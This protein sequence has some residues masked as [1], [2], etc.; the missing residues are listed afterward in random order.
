MTLHD[1][2]FLTGEEVVQF[3][4][5]QVGFFGGTHQVRDWGLLGSAVASAEFAAYYQPEADIFWVAAHYA[6]HIAQNQ[7][8][9][10]GNK[11]TGLV[12][13]F[14]FLQLNGQRFA[15][16]VESHPVLLRLM[17]DIAVRTAGKEDLAAFFRKHS[18]PLK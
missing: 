10:D 6:F 17:L 2:V 5:G 8:F 7:P 16:P 1:L 15:P 12:A 3:N 4:E 13:A 9:L 11:R 14:V 18:C